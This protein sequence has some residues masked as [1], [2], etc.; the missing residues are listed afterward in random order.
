ML[1]REYDNVL[2]R[3]LEFEVVGRVA[4]IEVLGRSKLRKKK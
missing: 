1:R 2:R 4:G 3:V